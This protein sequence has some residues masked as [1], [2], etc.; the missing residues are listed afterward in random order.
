MG[1]NSAEHQ[2]RINY[3]LKLRT[4][5]LQKSDFQHNYN[6]HQQQT[7]GQAKTPQNNM[8]VT[9]KVNQKF[10][11]NTNQRNSNQVNI[12]GSFAQ[13]NVSGQISLILHKSNSQKICSK[14]LK[15]S[16]L[17]SV[18]TKRQSSSRTGTSSSFQ[19]QQPNSRNVNVSKTQSN[20]QDSSNLRSSS[21]AL[22]RKSFRN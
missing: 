11:S 6:T 12:Q 13:N 22:G 3:D 1:A 7:T 9:V 5:H 21:S 15:P 14:C 17:Y 19:T 10:A 8:P 20:Q 16:T 18:Q 2:P 4:S